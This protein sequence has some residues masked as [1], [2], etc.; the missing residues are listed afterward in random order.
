MRN[1]TK[2]FLLIVAAFAVYVLWPRTPSFRNFDP[3]VLAKLKVE[4]WTAQRDGE[5]L[6]GLLARYKVFA[7]QYG[8]PPVTALHMARNQDVAMAEVRR[9]RLAGNGVDDTRAVAALTEKYVMM[10]R[11]TKDASVDADSLARE[12]VTWCTLLLDKAAPKDVAVPQAQL[13]AAR[14]G[15]E[16]K[17]FADVAMNLAYAQVLVF[18]GSAS[19]AE[20]GW[21]ARDYAREGYRQLKEI[22]AK[23]PTRS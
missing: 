20:P 8:F 10:K 9:L 14:Y 21:T 4:D 2:L 6:A 17:Q 1:I 7:S 18:H 13:L 16:A 5:A 3:A 15:G 23:P 12:E 19:G 22:V 11:G